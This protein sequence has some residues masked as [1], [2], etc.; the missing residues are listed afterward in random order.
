[1]RRPSIGWERGVGHARHKWSSGQCSNRLIGYHTLTSLQ[2]Q[3]KKPDHVYKMFTV[4]GRS[5]WP[6][7]GRARFISLD[8]PMPIIHAR[9]HS[10]THDTQRI[11][12]S[13]NWTVFT[14]CSSGRN[15]STSALFIVNM[16]R[17]MLCETLFHIPIKTN[18]P[19][20]QP[21]LPASFSQEILPLIYM[22][23]I[24]INITNKST[25][26]MVNTYYFEKILIY[27]NLSL[28]PINNRNS[29]IIDTGMA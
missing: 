23:E 14:P 15:S 11:Q 4:L 8:Y 27:V 20:P 26:N 13:A 10:L 18:S 16:S 22:G 1:M 7:R 5:F 24:R 12:S 6:L 2:H 9:T 3:V 25:T 19:R 29:I 21:S 17:D 28:L